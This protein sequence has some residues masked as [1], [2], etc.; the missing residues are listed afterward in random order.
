[1]HFHSVC[2][3]IISS[4]WRQ[5]VGAITT[6]LLRSVGKILQLRDSTLANYRFSIIFSSVSMLEESERTHTTLVSKHEK[7]Y[8]TC[9]YISRDLNYWYKLRNC[10]CGHIEQQEASKLQ[11]ILKYFVHVHIKK[12]TWL[13]IGFLHF[14]FL[15]KVLTSLTDTILRSFSLPEL[16]RIVYCALCLNQQLAIF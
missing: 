11:R 15:R 10:F 4:S 14:Y 16:Q 6:I 5:R 7:W 2:Q 12:H 8:F 1:M 9:I 13:H 3:R